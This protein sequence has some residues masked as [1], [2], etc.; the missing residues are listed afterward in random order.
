MAAANALYSYQGQEPKVLPH[1]ISWTESWGGT[2]FRTG[3]E[4]FTSEEITKAGYTG[5]YVKPNFNEETHYLEWDL[6]TYSY[7]ILEIIHDPPYYP[8]E[9][10]LWE[11]LRYIR[12]LF[13]RQ[14]DW[15]VLPDNSL[16]TSQ[17]EE[18]I[19]YRKLLRD[20]PNKFD[21]K[22]VS[23]YE[24]LDNLKIWSDKPNF[25]TIN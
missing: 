20:Y 8:T 2:T 14:T 16:S 9:E 13:L 25:I 21:I 6:E 4:S 17:T 12:N 18:I 22:T 23:T 7:K 5:P 11:R 3:V 24:D 15:T 19:E 10:E 1:E